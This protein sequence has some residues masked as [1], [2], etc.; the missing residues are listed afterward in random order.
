MQN[1]GWLNNPACRNEI[2]QASSMCRGLKH[3]T[4]DSDEGT[5]YSGLQHHVVCK[6]CDY[7][8]FYC[9]SD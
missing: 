2:D 7:E 1:L 3:Q 4:F 9:S 5:P 6:E 8:Y